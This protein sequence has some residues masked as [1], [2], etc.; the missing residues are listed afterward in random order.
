MII[1]ICTL[2][3]SST[4]TVNFYYSESIMGRNLVYS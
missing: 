3:F 2:E 4:K 1:I